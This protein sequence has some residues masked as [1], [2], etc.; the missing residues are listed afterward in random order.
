[1]PKIVAFADKA[2]LMKAAAERIA[3][4]IREAIAQRGGACI[5]LSGGSTP[6]PAYQLLAAMP[7]EWSK[8]T[9]ALVDERFVPPSDPASNEGMI[10]RALAPAFAGGARFKPL[11]FAADSVE[12]A[13]LSADAQYAHLEIDFAVMGMGEDGHTA[14]W[15]P[16]ADGLTQ[17]LDPKT[18]ASV[19]FVRAL[20]A[21][22]AAARLTVTRAAYDRARAALLMIT[23]EAKRTTLEATVA[24]PFETAPV[25]ALFAPGA[26]PIEVLWA[27]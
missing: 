27:P 26:P 16:G 2:A 1:M 25:A 10:K 24:A 9:F 23:G 17:A 4:A 7:L 22:G 11:F 6:E 12:L 15:F 5:A 3:T 21:T 14:S 13:A 8:V 19:T 18:T 20:N